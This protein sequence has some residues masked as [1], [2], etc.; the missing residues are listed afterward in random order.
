MAKTGNDETAQTELFS[1]ETTWFHIFKAMISNGDIAAMGPYA[2]TIY[3][4]IKAHT[5]FNTGVSFP[6]IDLIAEKTGISLAQ[7]KRELKTLEEM[8]YV[9]KEKQGR[10]NL[11]QLREK[12]EIQDAQGQPHGVA[13]WDYLPGG[14][15]AAVAELKK[16]MVSG[17]FTGGKIINIEKM[18]LKV[19]VNTGSGTQINFDNLDNLDLSSMKDSELKSTLQTLLEKRSKSKDSL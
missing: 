13:T 1:A 14:V 5:N 3:C 18:V 8:G 12:L 16:M 19:N 2:F 10:S 15:Q 4:I 6:S 7:I 17:E 11:Y 9:T